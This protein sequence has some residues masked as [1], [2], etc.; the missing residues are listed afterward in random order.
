MKV[1]RSVSGRVQ[2][3]LIG[4]NLRRSTVHW[5]NACVLFGG[6]GTFAAPW[7]LSRCMLGPRTPTP[8][9][10]PRKIALKR[11]APKRCM[12]LLHTLGPHLEGAASPFIRSWIHH[13]DFATSCISNPVDKSEMFCSR[14]RSSQ[15]WV[16]RDAM[17]TDS[18]D[19]RN[20]ISRLTFANVSL[21]G[22]VSSCSHQVTDCTSLQTVTEINTPAPAAQVGVNMFA[23]CATKNF[24][25][26]WTH[27]KKIPSICSYCGEWD[28][29]PQRKSYNHH[30]SVLLPQ[31]QDTLFPGNVTVIN[32][33]TMKHFLA[34]DKINPDHNLFGVFTQA[35]R[36]PNFLTLASKF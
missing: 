1:S 9:P 35:G 8:P 28:H 10:P 31:Q 23:F 11:F 17:S 4:R 32:S 14:P 18:K 20:Q 16:F 12:F 5:F 25:V 22:K 21:L 27:S 24:P 34:A 3:P 33:P 29:P 13:C 19:G 6:W 36:R 2:G 15:A 26:H 30:C 7:V